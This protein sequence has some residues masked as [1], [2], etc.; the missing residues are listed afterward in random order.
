[1]REKKNMPGIYHQHTLGTESTL[2]RQTAK[3]FR[4]TPLSH[5]LR[6]FKAEYK[7]IT[8]FQAKNPNGSTE[9]NTP[10]LNENGFCELFVET[11]RRQKNL[12]V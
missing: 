9:L 6:F 5:S 8:H 7:L 12:H 11:I 2:S 4:L 10:M 3:N 1:V